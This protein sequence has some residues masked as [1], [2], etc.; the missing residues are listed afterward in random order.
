MMIINNIIKLKTIVI[1]QENIE[2][3]LMLCVVKNVK[4][5][6]RFQFYFIMDLLMII[7]L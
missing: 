6:R 2:E 5:K 3:Q 1:I 7:I 4:Y